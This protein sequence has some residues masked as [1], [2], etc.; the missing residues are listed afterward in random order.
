MIFKN[1]VLTLQKTFCS[2]YEG[3]VD[4]RVQLQALENMELNL[5]VP[6]HLGSILTK[7]MSVFG[8]Q[9]Q[10]DSHKLE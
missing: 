4:D 7:R 6:L 3:V 1:P 9:Q 8:E 10:N 2:S 5:M